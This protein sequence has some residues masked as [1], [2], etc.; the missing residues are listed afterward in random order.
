MI[1][2][3]KIRQGKSIDFKKHLNAPHYIYLIGLGIIT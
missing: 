1:Y 3:E 2:T